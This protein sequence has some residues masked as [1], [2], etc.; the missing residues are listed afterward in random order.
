M[1]LAGDEGETF[2]PANLPDSKRAGE[3]FGGGGKKDGGDPALSFLSLSLN[4]D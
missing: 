3:Y 2:P 4:R 1:N